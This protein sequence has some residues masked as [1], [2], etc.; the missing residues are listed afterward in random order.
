MEEVKV[1]EEIDIGD[2]I[3]E[4]RGKQVMLD[5]DL[6]KLYQVETKRINEAVK[7][8]PA[9]FPER[10]CFKITLEEFNFF[11]S[12]IATLDKYNNQKGHNIKY[13]PYVFTEQGVAMLATILKSKVAIQ[14]SI[15]IMDAFVAMKRYISNNYMEQKYMKD[16]L[17]KHDNDITLLKES[18]KKFDEKKKVNDIYYKGQ[19]YDAYSRIVDI[20]KSAKKE[21]VVIDNYADKN[22]LDI[23]RKVSVPV[24][25]ITKK[26]PQFTKL[27]LKKYNSQYHN[28]VVIYDNSFHDRY[29]IIDKKD[30]YH[31]GASANYAGSK[32]FG[33]NILEDDIAK[34]GLISLTNKMIKNLKTQL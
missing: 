31:C 10:F 16:M 20:I 30:V 33:I 32:V 28:L 21:I 2:M 3:Y 29:F 24:V 15:R 27:D 6:A 7:R 19:I 11:R 1:S 8:N 5:S 18:F 34:K 14:M 12:Q 22:I 23:I 17:I 26:P 25:I 9:K 4:I 13:M